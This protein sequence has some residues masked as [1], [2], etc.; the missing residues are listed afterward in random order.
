MAAKIKNYFKRAFLEMIES[1]Q[2]EVNRRIAQG[3]FGGWQ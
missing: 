1:R 3:G 2:R